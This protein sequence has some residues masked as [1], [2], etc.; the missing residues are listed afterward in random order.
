MLGVIDYFKAL[1]RKH[2]PGTTELSD[3]EAVTRAYRL[4]SSQEHILVNRFL[5]Y[6]NRHPRVRMIGGTEADASRV[7][8]FSFVVEGKQSDEITRAAD[9]Y[10]IGIRYGDFYA[11]KIIKDLGLIEKNGVVRVSMLHY[12]TLDEVEHLIEALDSIL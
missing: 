10:R 1:V 4:I 12:N 5:S 9:P 7:P 2:E 8:T 11:K 3:R 6:L